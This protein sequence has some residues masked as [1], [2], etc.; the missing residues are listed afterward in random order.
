[1]VI[2]NPKWDVTDALWAALGVLIIGGIVYI[3][4]I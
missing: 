3:A 2:T 4:S 1:M